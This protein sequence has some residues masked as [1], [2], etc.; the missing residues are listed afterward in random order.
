MAFA[1]N[2]VIDNHECL[3]IIDKPRAGVTYKVRNLATGEI[4]ALRAL[5]GATSRNP[6][7]V[8]R[9]LREIRLHARLSHPNI[10]MFHD[11]FEIDGQLVMSTEFV[12]GPT[13][14]E[15]CREGPLP[16][17]DAI[18]TIIPVL[19][20]LEEAHALGI[21][22]RGVTAEHVFVTPD[23]TVKLGG[24]GLAKPV[25]DAN[26]TQVGTVVGDPRYISPE[27]VMGQG[28]LDG[29]SDLYSVGVLLY[30]ALTGKMPFEGRN[31]FEVLAAQVGSEPQPPSVVN[32]AISP[33]LDR[34]VLRALRKRPDERFPNAR[35]FRT[36]LAAALDTATQPVPRVADRPD[37]VPRHSSVQHTPRQSLATPLVAGL[38]ILAIG[39]AIVAWVAVH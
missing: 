11:A 3:G 29:R 31:D 15:L 24:F 22:H 9:L 17:R 26:L 14:A 6:E 5:P 39:L 18:G 10:I 8:E 23:G 38:L 28:T 4:E 27:Q 19:D 2:Q 16:L 33:E 1:L 35:E 13:L 25:A 21:V 37:A 36:A 32:P 34:I 30:Q 7:F 12:E 20:G